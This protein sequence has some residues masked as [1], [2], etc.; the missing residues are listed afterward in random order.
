MP[1]RHD[2]AQ[3]APARIT[4]GELAVVLSHYELGVIDAV[5][6]F[7][8]GSRQSPKVLIETP[9]GRFLLK[10]RPAPATGS[11]HAAEARKVAFT[12]EV[13][14]H[15]ARH[16]FPVPT[17]IGTRGGNNSML[18]LATGVYELH[19]FVD[20]TRYAR[21]P[22]QAHAAGWWQGRCHQL[23]AELSTSHPAPRRSYHDHPRI[24]PKLAQIAAALGSDDAAAL[25]NALSDAYTHAARRATELGAAADPLQVVHGDWHPGNMLFRESTAEA[26]RFVP[27]RAPRAAG[28]VS[29]VFDFDA[30]RMGHPLHDLANG[31]MQFAVHRHTRDTPTS[32]DPSTPASPSQWR[33]ALDPA[34]LHAFFAG[35]AAARG[36]LEP[37]ARAA[38]PWLMIEA[39]I[40]EVVVPIGVTGSFGKLSALP[41]LNL[42]QRAVDALAGQSERL[43]ALL[44]EPYPS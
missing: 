34:L 36:P 7:K 19:R 33:I 10:R 39:L 11:D 22:E 29:G 13:V 16:E 32:P 20:G 43:V 24:V 44:A 18:E 25:C 26:I 1:Q 31:G 5:R 14:L 9:A 4:A 21:R 37:A 40:V 8:G 27:P 2:P 35:H 6:R 17:L 41:V 42:V 30:A 28:L 38:V 23:L 12:H 3:P 15:L